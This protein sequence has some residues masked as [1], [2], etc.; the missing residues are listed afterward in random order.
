MLL[1]S[2]SI[3]E[4]QHSTADNKLEV[5]RFLLDVLAAKQSYRRGMRTSEHW[6]AVE[7]APDY[8]VAVLTLLER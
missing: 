6:M 3:I 8:H 7:S 5:A 4:D 2:L 1:H